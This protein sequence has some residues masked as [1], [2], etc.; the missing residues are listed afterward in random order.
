MEES[1]AGG[2]SSSVAANTRGAAAGGHNNGASGAIGGCGGSSLASLAGAGGASVA[3]K[4]TSSSLGDDLAGTGGVKRHRSGGHGG[5]GGHGGGAEPRAAPFVRKLY[6]MV[7]AHET[8][9]VIAWSDEGR[10]FW[11]KVRPHPTPPP[12]HRRP[13]S[14]HSPPLLSTPRPQP[15][16]AT[17]RRLPSPLLSPSLHHPSSPVS[18]LHPLLSRVH[19]WQVPDALEAWVLPQ[20]F[21]H[22]RMSFF[23]KQLK[24]YGF[25][26]RIGASVLAVAKEWCARARRLPCSLA[27]FLARWHCV[28][29]P[30]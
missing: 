22:N 21:K 14:Q 23:T 28:S 18:C 20:F 16:S 8:D 19:L 29:P 25:R 1:S 5:H 24:A 27:P 6:D 30:T 11:I 15:L 13:A 10:S 3:S 4:R 26:P 7:S 9:A 2:C 17:Q 12:Y